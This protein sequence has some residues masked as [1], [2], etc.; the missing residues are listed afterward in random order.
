M[1]WLHLEDAAIPMNHAHARADHLAH[2]HQRPWP[3]GMVRFSM[4]GDNQLGIMSEHANVDNVRSEP[5]MDLGFSAL[6]RAIDLHAKAAAAAAAAGID[7]PLA[8]CGSRFACVGGV[9]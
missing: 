7:L 1:V 6:G 2:R 5:A 8:Q 9:L 3:S 4:L